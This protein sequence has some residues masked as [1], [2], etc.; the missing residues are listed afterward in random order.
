M[1]SSRARLPRLAL[2]LALAAA[3]MM[4]AACGAGQG[5]SD[6]LKNAIIEFNEG[7]RWG[8]LND[9]LAHLDPES[10]DHFLEMHKEFGKDIQISGYEVVNTVVDMDQGVAEVGVKVTWYRHSKMEVH[11]T[12]LMQRWEEKDREWWMIAEEYRSGEPF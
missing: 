12:V 2:L 4:L 7:V 9:V 6:K 8:R 11:E 10:Q 1:P 5:R 3:A